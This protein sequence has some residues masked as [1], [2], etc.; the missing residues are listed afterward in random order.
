MQRLLLYT[1]F[2]LLVACAL[3]L[4]QSNSASGE[5]KGTV[6]DPSGAVVPGATITATNLE[7][8][9]APTSLSDERG[10]YRILLL[11]PGMYGVRVERNGFVAEQ[12]NGVQVTV[13]QTA[14]ADFRL[15]VGASVQT[16]LVTGETPVVE[17]E[18][19]QQSN[20]ISEAYIRNL[21]IDRRDYLSFSLL[22]PG[23]SDSNRV[24]DNT[25]F[26]AKQTPQ[27]GLS[28][29]GSNGRGN[30]IT[31]DG[32]ET[33]DSTGGV[34]STLGQ[35]AIQE[36]QINRS[37][38]SA[39]L[40][41]ASGGVINII[42]KSGTNS[43]H[44]KLFAYF[45][46]QHLDAA[47]PFA[48]ELEEDNSL[49]R[50]KPPATRQ[51]YGA[52]LGMPLKKDR[53]F[54]FASFEGLNRSESSVVSVLTDFNIFQPTPQ[55]AAI[56]AKLAAN[57]DLTPISCL[58]TVSLP[59]ASCAV[60]LKATLTAKPKTME[61][62]KSN[63]G[64][65]PF[66]TDSRAFSLRFDHRVGE[67]HQTFLRYNYTSSD[68]QNRN[69][70]A[71]VGFSRSDNLDVLDSNVVAGWTWILNSNLVNES[72]F[73]W[74]YRHYYVRSNESNGPE[75]NITG[76]GYFNRDI[77]L[78]GLLIGR[79]YE[80][81]DSLSYLHGKHRMK[82]GFNF[83]DRTAHSESYTF[84]GGRFG[85]GDLP[86]GPF[87]PPL[88]SASIAA[89]Q[90]FDLGL[91]QSYQQGFGDPIFRGTMP[92]YAFYV[93]DSWTPRSNLT[94]NFGLRYELDVRSSPVPT[95]KN[96]FAPRIGFAWDPWNNK[97]TVIRGGFGIYYAQIYAQIDNIV[98]TLVEINGYRQ[99]AQVLSPL[100]PANASARNGP[101][102][103]FQT[104]LAQGVIGVP[105]SPRTIQVS[106]LSQ[107]GIFISHTGPRP[108]LTVLF[109]ID[110]N[111][112]NPYC[113]QG[114]LGIEHEIT[115]GLSAS[116]SYIFAR[117]AKIPRARD[118]NLI[119]KPGGGGFVF[120]DPTLYQYNNYESSANAFY[121]GMIF[122]ISRRFSRNLSLAGNYTLSKAIDEV[123]DSNSDYQANDQTYLRAERALSAFDQ[124]HK[125]VF[126]ASLQSPYHMD[127]ADSP[128][129][130]L[131]ADFAL[132]PVFRY[133][134]PRPFN[135]LTG[136]DTNGDRHSTTDR[137]LF[138][139]R[140]T[141]IG[142]DF[143]TVDL[144]L[145]RVMRLGGERRILEVTAE[146]FNLF[147][148]LNYASVNNTV[149]PNFSGPFHIQANPGLGPSAPLGYISA[150]EARRFQLGLRFSF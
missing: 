97:R 98:N 33:N 18:R 50:I 130:H 103:I 13:G 88:G 77:F 36:F 17:T 60:A 89:V 37:N 46:D 9:L 8:G 22:A 102:N 20:T 117:T 71:L 139:G 65:F 69:T 34:R 138:S 140:N 57:P 83:L 7:T 125:V 100:N 28:F 143:W 62:F 101:I 74:N 131:L 86:G 114:T 73:Q 136:V 19:S 52:T 80:V 59:P 38:Y 32:A 118:V 92:Y 63:S 48:M 150:A 4:A 35:E 39:E 112:R 41:G 111:Y 15:Q 127:S 120:K 10:Q 147:N 51:Q 144:R 141:G 116:A 56:I 135:L 121:H 94:L 128:A 72:R 75:F 119:P 14:S 81:S 149:G 105:T 27:S 85:F 55:Q 113:E 54:L 31:I 90:A 12:R 49:R 47:D 76:Y 123:T 104:L 29:Y 40:G 95:D 2:A 132:T 5:L 133:S 66:T 44:G 107:F 26:R 25:D 122:E 23:V 142:P 129:K 70:H 91:V 145:S 124:R 11:P 148:H 58:P 30:S 78:P 109:Q 84:M 53:T 108:P 68:D 3:S 82:F 115:N 1:T 137:P 42:S 96:N 146:A 24:V 61:L 134:S 16:I 99:I 64:V 87:I 79:R 110:P 45:R 43:L 106:D 126:Y 93:Q 6:S 67:K 21:P